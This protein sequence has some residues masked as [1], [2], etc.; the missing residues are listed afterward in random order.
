MKSFFQK[1]AFKWDLLRGR[2][3]CQVAK[4]DEEIAACV[5]VLEEVRRKEL[6]RVAGES[7]LDSHAFSGQQ[8]NYQLIA[9]RDTKTNQIIGCMRITDAYEAKSVP[10][11]YREYHLDLFSDELLKTLKIFTRLAILKPYRK[12]AAS[13]TLMAGAFS[14]VFAAGGQAVLLSCEPNLLAMYKRL[15]IRPIGQPHNSPSGGYRIPMIF[16]PDIPHMKKVKSPALPLIGHFD[17]SHCDPIMEWYEQR[18]VELQNYQFEAEPFHFRSGDAALDAFITAGISEKGRK[19]FLK[20]AMVVKCQLDDVIVAESDGG[21]SI[22]IVKKGKVKVVKEGGT[23]VELKTGDVFGEIAF[24]LN[25]KRTATLMAAEENTE[26]LLFS[27]SAIKRLEKESDQII[28][29]QN[30]AK[31]LAERLVQRTERSSM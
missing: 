22:G 24:V 9:C 26:V 31:V 18:K 8:L 11:S 21:K 19:D 14:E 16:L 23:I 15:G 10:A 28:V 12:T 25:S 17:C 13:L 20:N 7:V 1:V 2:F 29:W 30:L 4:T 6:N 27:V 5:H 3:D